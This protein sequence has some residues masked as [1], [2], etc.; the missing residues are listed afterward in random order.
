[1]GPESALRTSKRPVLALSLLL[2]LSTL[3]HAECCAQM[4]VD[5]F[6]VEASF[7]LTTHLITRSLES[8]LPKRLY[9]VSG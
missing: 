5:F 3:V 7:P 1:V 9:Y 6:G 2:L 8:A 4:L